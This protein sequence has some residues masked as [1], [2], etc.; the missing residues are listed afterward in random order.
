MPG[1]TPEVEV[2]CTAM[3][4]ERAKGTRMNPHH[5][6][7][8]D[9]LFYASPKVMVTFVAEVWHDGEMTNPADECVLME[10]AWDHTPWSL[11]EA[12]AEAKRGGGKVYVEQDVAAPANTGLDMVWVDEGFSFEVWPKWTGQNRHKR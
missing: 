1:E 7:E 6:M 10:Y 8:D 5:K 11:L 4:R 9:G 12:V 3:A 2:I